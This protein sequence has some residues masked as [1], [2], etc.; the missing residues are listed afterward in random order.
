MKLRVLHF[1]RFINRF[2]CIDTVLSNLNRA[3]FEPR[4]LTVSAPTNRVGDYRKEEEYDAKCLNT[5]FERRHYRQIYA[6]LLKE[7]EEFKPHILQAH[8]YDETVMGALAFK[9]LKVPAFVIGHHYSDHIYNS[10]SG[11]KLKAYLAVEKWCNKRASRVV[12]PSRHVVEILTKQGESEEKVKAIPIGTDFNM[13][14]TVRSAEVEAIR[15]ENN[16]EG[17]FVAL[18]C[19]RLHREKGLDY[20]LRAVA[21]LKNKFPQLRLVMAGTG[22]HEA[23]MRRLAEDL[24][25]ADI[26]SFIGWRKDA[27]HWIAASDFVLQPSVSESFCQVLTESLAFF[28]PVLMTPVGVAPEVIVNN[29]RGGYLVPFSDDKAIAAAL[30]EAITQPEKARLLAERGNEYV[31]RYLSVDTSARLY[32]NLYRDVAKERKISV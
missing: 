11:L 30:E 27:L 25:I 1:A 3:E 10:T 19:C 21:V 2:D 7:I 32:E 18:T 20:V 4:A 5:D 14:D 24:N 31:R 13:L 8:H 28:K 29:E 17:K 22:P 15:R 12:V 23:D 9:K 16:L 26:V 6:A